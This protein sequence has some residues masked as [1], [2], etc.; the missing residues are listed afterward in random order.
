MSL[1]QI[2][3]KLATQKCGCAAGDRGQYHVAVSLQIGVHNVHN[4]AQRKP[5]WE[6]PSTTP[7][8]SQIQPS[9]DGQIIV[10][11]T[12][13]VAPNSVAPDRPVT[14]GDIVGAYIEIN[15]P[16]RC[17]QSLPQLVSV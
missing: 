10:G 5:S 15:Y 9:S 12:L 11:A 2:D 17:A 16:R 1:N 3:F 7:S 6:S 13:A 14:V 8:N 4:S